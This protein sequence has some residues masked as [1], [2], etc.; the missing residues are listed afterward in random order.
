MQQ[1]QQQQQKE[2]SNLQFTISYQPKISKLV[3]GV[4]LKNTRV[5]GGGLGVRGERRKKKDESYEQNH[6]RE[7]GKREEP[8]WQ[9]EWRA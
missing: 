3:V 8:E 5:V 2:V 1:Q 4:V 6:K 7:K 9:Q